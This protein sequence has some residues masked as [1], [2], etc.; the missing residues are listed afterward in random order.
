[1]IS[2]TI[3]YSARLFGVIVTLPLGDAMPSVPRLFIAF[4]WGICLAAQ[5]PY[6]GISLAWYQL[7]CE[8]LIG[9]LLSLPI[10]VLVESVE[11]LGELL[12]T[13]RGQ[14]VGSINDPLNGSHT[15]DMASVF[16]VAAATLLL[17]LGALEQ[18]VEAVRLSYLG[19]PLGLSVISDRY[20]ATVGTVSVSIISSSLSLGAVWFVSYLTSDLISALLAKVSHGLAFTS[21]SALLKMGL[22]LLLLL[23]LVANPSGVAPLNRWVEFP[24]EL[25]RS[26][27]PHG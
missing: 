5:D 13:S 19:I 14:T 6:H 11:M 7:A 26:G 16:R 20:A 23:R 8:F 2:T 3:A 18:T 9:L 17:N 22:T 1:M 15:S 21:T 12:D 10:R 25:A 27:V 4:C 24:I